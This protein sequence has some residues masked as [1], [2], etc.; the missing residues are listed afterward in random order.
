MQ[1]DKPTYQTDLGAKAH[2]DFLNSGDGQTLKQIA[3]DAI[4][5]RLQGKAELS[6]LDAGCGQGW[7]SKLLTDL[8]HKVMACDISPQLIARAQT[9]FP[10]LSFQIADL[11]KTLPYQDGWFDCAILCLSALDLRDQRAAFLEINRVLKPKGLLII[12]TVNPYYGFPAGVW[13]RGLIGKF[14]MRKPK[15]KLNNYFD[16]VRKQD[17][18]F[19]WNKEK[20][21]SYFYTLPEQINLLISLKFVIS[22]LD[23][24]TSAQDDTEFSLR[25][26]LYRFPIFLLMEFIKP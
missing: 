1:I 8:G 21:A 18:H 15:L 5:K 11:T 22:H 23:D 16:L 4:L 17:R 6:V 13:K 26:R 20:Q 10:N 25:H 24:I 12:F 9:D 2:L 7:L 14:L 3:G 19:F